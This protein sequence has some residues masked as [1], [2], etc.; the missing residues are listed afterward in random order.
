MADKHPYVSGTGV[1]VQVLDH[2]KKSF[3]ANL[4]AEV[5]KKLGFAP[6][7]ESYIINTVRFLKLIDD[8]GARTEKAQKTFTLHD[9]TSFQKAISDIVKTA[10]ADLFSLHGDGAWSLEDPKLI[11]FFRQTDQ[12][13]E[14]VGTR[15]A[16]TFK[17]LAAYAGHVDLTTVTKVRTS[18]RDTKPSPP[19]KQRSSSKGAAAVETHPKPQ[20]NVGANSETSDSGSRNLGLTV[21]IEINLPASG[22]QEAYDR[23][24]KSIRENLLNG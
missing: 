12:S 17:A 24:F 1:L 13:S 15:Q 5:L 14:L 8:K 16:G 9:I 2:L 10:Y 19:K 22:D 4:N 18:N 23:I 7:N 6:K 3:P 20:A 11:T 21:R